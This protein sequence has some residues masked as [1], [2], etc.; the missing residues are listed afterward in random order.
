MA[1]EVINCLENMKLIANEEETITISE[2]GKRL[3]IES[4]TL[5]LIGK[6]LTCK[7][8]NKKAAKTTIRRA[9]GL[10]DKWK[11][12]MKAEN[13]QLEHASLWVQIWGAPFD[14]V[15]PQVAGEVRG[16]DGERSW[17]TFKYECL[18]MFCHYCGLLGHD[19]HHCANHFS[20]TKSEKEIDYQYGDWL[21]AQGGR[22][23]SP[24][25]QQSEMK[26]DTGDG[27]GFWQTSLF[28]EPA[29]EEGSNENPK[30]TERR[31]ESNA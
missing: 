8:F 31:V 17:V 25:K 30:E 15:S 27:Q 21:K 1:E 28:S 23:S 18:P 4:C 24:M 19:L 16:S 13:V 3:D 5:S 9:W 11:K 20:A 22:P 6:F 10:E 29:V 14:M 12:G 26:A 2:E 7:P